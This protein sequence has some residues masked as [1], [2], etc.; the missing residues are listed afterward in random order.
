[1]EGLVKLEKQSAR[2]VKQRC[3]YAESIVALATLYI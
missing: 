1:M 3:E 2:C